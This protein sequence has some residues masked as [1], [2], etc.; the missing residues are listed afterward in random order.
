V[1]L[2]ITGILSGIISGMGI[3]GGC[4]LIP[5]LVILTGIEQHAAQSIN[6]IYFIPTAVVALVVH[7]IKK[8]I[9]F[10]TAIPVALAGMAGA[11]AGSKLAISMEGA[12][13]RK[14]FG[15]FLLIVGI[16]EII[17][18]IQAEKT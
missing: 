11:F 9:E 15:A 10:K 6:L 3:G 14:L 8:S 17:K 13:L 2:L 16:C 7:I 4:I 5:A 12:I 18:G 1:V